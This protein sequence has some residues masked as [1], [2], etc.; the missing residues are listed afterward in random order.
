MPKPITLDEAAQKLQALVE[1]SLK[2]R[3]NDIKDVA[4]AFS[5]GL[6]SSLVAYLASK[7]GLKVNLLHVSME[8]QAETEEAIVASEQLNL[9]LQVDLYK[10][11]D[12]EKTLPKVVELIEEADPI[13]ASIGLPFYWMAE[14]AAEAGLHVVV[15]WAGCG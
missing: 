3:T 8:N 10:D 2:R 13:K 11:S 12:V 9:P 7:L 1:E 14:Q 4:V 6:D 5:G 15:G